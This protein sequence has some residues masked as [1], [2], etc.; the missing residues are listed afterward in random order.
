MQE[1][2]LELIK[3]SNF[4][5]SLKFYGYNK[6]YY[7]VLADRVDVLRNTLVHSDEYER[8]DDCLNELS[9]ILA[10]FHDGVQANRKSIVI[11]SNEE[12]HK[13]IEY[14]KIYER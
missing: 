14:F 4:V 2:E 1:K 10:C 3:K 8:S 11:N 6:E 12:R 13:V 9:D 7:K 5:L